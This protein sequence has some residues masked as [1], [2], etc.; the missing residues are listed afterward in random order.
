M[1]RGRTPL[2]TPAHPRVGQRPDASELPRSIR[3]LWL[4][5][6]GGPSLAQVVRRTVRVDWDRV[7][8]LAVVDGWHEDAA[9]RLAAEIR[10]FL[11]ELHL[12]A[13]PELRCESPLSALLGE[14]RRSSVD[15]VILAA[16]DDRRCRRLVTA[17]FAYARTTTT[18]LHV[19]VDLPP[20][21][22][23]RW[24]LR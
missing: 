1:A 2:A 10:W 12:D 7:T 14:L 15:A 21:A 3:L 6:S 16:P 20:S 24:L 4:P 8:V 22:I 9:R 11:W 17:A 13:T 18:P 23:E 19:A 5:G